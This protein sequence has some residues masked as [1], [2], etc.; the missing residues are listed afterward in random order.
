MESEKIAKLARLNA[1]CVVSRHNRTIGVKCYGCGSDVRTYLPGCVD[2]RWDGP[3]LISAESV[4]DH[5]AH[6]ENEPCS[7][8]VELADAL[9][10]WGIPYSY[11]PIG[12]EEPAT[13]EATTSR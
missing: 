1:V 9:F 4:L 3:H 8:P 5:L 7:V 11:P 6:Q 10:G 12:M 2:G 13:I